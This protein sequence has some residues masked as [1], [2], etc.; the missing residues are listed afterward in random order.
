MENL[1]T[2]K[3][4]DRIKFDVWDIWRVPGGWIF[5]CDG[6]ESGMVSIFVPYDTNA[7]NDFVK[8]I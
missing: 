8:N 1:L 6:G 3:I 5:G 7:H 2:M 4:G